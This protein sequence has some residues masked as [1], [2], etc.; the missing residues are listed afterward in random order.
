[1][2]LLH[3]VF[4]IFWTVLAAPEV[5]MMGLSASKLGFHEALGQDH[6]FATL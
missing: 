1:M 6:W 3:R 5:A 2:L 4:A